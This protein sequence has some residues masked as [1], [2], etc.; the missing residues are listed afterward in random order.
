MNKKLK[1]IAI[2]ILAV[3]FIAVACIWIFSGG[4]EHIEDTNGPNN[5]ALATITDENIINQ[6]IGS[7]NFNMETSL[8]N[9]GITFSSEKFTGVYEIFLTNYIVPSDLLIQ[10]SNYQI[11]AGNFKMV[12]VHNDEI[13]YTFEPGLFPECYLQGLTGT[14]SLRVAGESAAFTFYMSKQTCDMFEI[15]IGS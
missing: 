4:M 12:I 14:V 7:L 8:L 5:Y 3:A 1:D 15:E 2:I 9:D 13:I 6:D 11:T 10:L